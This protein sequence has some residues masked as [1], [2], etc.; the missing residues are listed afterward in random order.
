MAS[1]RR[2]RPSGVSTPT[3]PIRSRLNAR[4]RS[5]RKFGGRS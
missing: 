4:A 5:K 3:N 2:L 1:R